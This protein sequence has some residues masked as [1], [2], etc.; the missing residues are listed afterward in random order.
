MKVHKLVHSGSL[1]YPVMKDMT[2][3]AERS[4][5]L[6]ESIEKIKG[7]KPI[8]L[9][10]IGTSG[11]VPC[12]IMSALGGYPILYLRKE[13]EYSHSS[14]PL[15]TP[16]DMEISHIRDNYDLVWVDDFISSGETFRGV[17]RRLKS[18]NL[19]LFA[20]AF[21][22]TCTL[23]ESQNIIDDFPAHAKSIKHHIHITR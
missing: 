11:L 16:S 21:T 14:S 20:I 10:C 22:G 3:Q 1:T 23:T 15:V 8:M 18:K 4:K 19:K 17:L 5:M 7:K 2:G 9:V 6:L 12:S 13:N